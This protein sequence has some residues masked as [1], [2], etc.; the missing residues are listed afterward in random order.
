M[1]WG[2]VAR[3]DF[4][5]A[6]RSRWIWVLSA[7]FVAMF[8]GSA[9]LRFV[10]GSGNASA[11]QNAGIV[12]L[13]VQFM[14]DGAAL[15]VPLIAIVVGY[16]A[17]VGERESGT[18]KLLLSLPHSRVDVVAGKVL[19]RSGVMALPVLLGF[20]IAGVVL[21]P[22]ANGFALGTFVGFALLTV[23]LAVV[24]VG[25]AVGISAAANTSRQAVVAAV[26]VFVMSTTLW[27]PVT[28]QLAGGIKDLFGLDPAGKI[29][30]QLFLKLLNPVASY[31]T[32]VTS[33]IPG[34]TPVDA[35]VDLFSFFIFRPPGIGEAFGDSLPLYFSDPFVVVYLLF[36]LVVPVGVGAL[37]FE[38]ADL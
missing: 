4:Q 31:K 3:K 11:Q 19:G 2:A 14:S 8:A 6:V 22:A 17:I 23:L 38:Q 18:L 10:L 28:G 24:F 25:I 35:R 1:S 27:G 36:W 32:L 15:L 26:S 16:A 37:L 21:L 9:A 5:D 12:V 29:R 13:F 30:V 20:L 7:L 33:L 34:V